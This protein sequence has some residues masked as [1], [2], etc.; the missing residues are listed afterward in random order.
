MGG[1]S[2]QCS[3]R[4]I[5]FQ[6]LDETRES[7][8]STNM[9]SSVPVDLTSEVHQLPCCIKFTGS[10]TI[11]HYFK[12]K[13]AGIEIEGLAVEEAYFRGRKLQGTTVMLPECFSGA[14]MIYSPGP[15]KVEELLVPFKGGVTCRD[16]AMVG[17]GCYDSDEVYLVEWL[18]LGQEGI[19]KEESYSD[20]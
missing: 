4:V 16:E 1:A 8:G 13:L 3:K 15:Y 5:M 17:L 18:C 19:S 2:W 9:C 14:D 12:P 11:S 7:R 6:M 20:V 10:S